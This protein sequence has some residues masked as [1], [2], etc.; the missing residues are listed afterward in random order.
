[1]VDLEVPAF[2]A[3]GDNTRWI[4]CFKCSPDRRRNRTA[5]MRN[6]LYVN[7]IHLEQ[8]H[9]TARC[10][11]SGGADRDRTH[12]RDTTGFAGRGGAARKR[13]LRNVD[14]HDRFRSAFTVDQRYE[15]VC[16]VGLAVLALS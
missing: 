15:R 4:A 12:A 6:A 10:E 7:A 2:V 8:L 14:V 9:R 16:R 1:M 3:T 5:C 13:S 11:T